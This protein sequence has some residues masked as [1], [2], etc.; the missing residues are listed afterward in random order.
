[1]KNRRESPRY[2][3]HG[4]Y[5]SE[6]LNCLRRGKQ[7]VVPPANRHRLVDIGPQGLGFVSASWVPKRGR[8]RVFYVSMPGE[9]MPHRVKGTVVYTRDI[10]GELPEGMSPIWRQSSAYRASRVGVRL[11]EIPDALAALIDAGG[12]AP[13]TGPA[14]EERPRESGRPEQRRGEREAP[15]AER[16]G[17]LT[18]AN[19]AL[20]ADTAARKQAEDAPW[21]SEA[22][23][24][25]LV[26]LAPAVCYRLD[27]RG[28]ITFISSGVAAFGYEPDELLGRF[29][30]DLVH[31]DDLATLGRGLIERRTGERVTRQ[32]DIRLRRKSADASHSNGNYVDV[33][34]SAQGLW[35]I[36]D[37]ASD[38][39]GKRF[40]GTQG[41]IHDITERKRSEQELRASRELL[42]S[43]AAR[44]QDIREQERTVLARTIHD[45]L[46]HALTSLKWDLAWIQPRLRKRAGEGDC[47]EV[48][49][50]IEA[51]DGRVDET[52][53]SIRRLATE[54]RPAILD[55]LGIG[56][57]VEWQAQ[58]F[59]DRTGIRCRVAI[60]PPD[61]ALDQVRSDALFRIFQ[62]VLTNVARHAQASKLE[63]TLALGADDVVLCVRDDGQGLSNEVASGRDRLGLLGIQERIRLLAGEFTIESQ[64]G[65]GTTVTVRIPVG[66]A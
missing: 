59:G 20:R 11:E 29:L 26:E 8:S 25:S 19:R 64:P 54:L 13:A 56:A 24:R 45:E 65:E 3:L 17:K 44:L 16:L 50:R 48:M 15:V 55:H 58:Q 46:G 43:L 12:K 35:D 57:A 36:E 60:S 32:R 21:E 40:L 66:G 6:G 33:Q 52:I 27:P 1:M 53:E 22:R 2:S 38:Q 63:T 31:P 14:R 4:S 61:L 49:S 39:E 28:R 47:D 37:E 23:Y 34:I 18:E 41:M 42:R 5:V 7:F 51:M 9:T 62:E 10:Y 30:G